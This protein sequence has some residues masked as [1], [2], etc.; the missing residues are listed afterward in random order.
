MWQELSIYLYLPTV[1]VGV[2]STEKVE[3]LLGYDE[4]VGNKREVYV[5]SIL[6]FIRR[7]VDLLRTFR[8]DF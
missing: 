5:R 1:T 4:F 7:Q 2:S 3:L 6:Y 8:N